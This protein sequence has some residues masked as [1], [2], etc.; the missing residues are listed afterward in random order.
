MLVDLIDEL[1]ADYGFN[2]QKIEYG[3]GLFYPYFVNEDNTDTLAPL[4]ELQC[5]LVQLNRKVELTIEMGRF[6]A[7]ECGTYLTKV[8]DTKTNL[9]SHYAILD[10]GIHHVNYYGGNMGLRIPHIK[11]L[12][13]G[14]SISETS[15]EWVLCGSLCTTADII[16]RSIPICGLAIGDVLAFENIGAYSV[17]EGPCLFLSRNMPRILLRNEEGIQIA[18]DVV[19]TSVLNCP[20]F[21]LHNKENENE[22]NN[23]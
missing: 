14:D 19:H 8:V 5:D 13:S 11:F 20:D 3:P 15:K 21:F 22:R 6:F 16:V 18:R 9:G 12:H 1:K 10:G 2:V 4:R 7:S 17:T 23:Y